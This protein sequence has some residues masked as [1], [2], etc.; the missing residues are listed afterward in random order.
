M[1]ATGYPAAPVLLQEMWVSESRFHRGTEPD[2]DPV[3]EAADGVCKA[4]DVDDASD[5]AVNL[6]WERLV[7]GIDLRIAFDF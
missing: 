2:D 4:R 5:Y 3:C 1:G 7:F 6:V